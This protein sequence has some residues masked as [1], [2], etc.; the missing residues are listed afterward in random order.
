MVLRALCILLLT[1]SF[2]AVAQ[3]QLLNGGFEIPDPNRATQWFTPP[4]HWDSFNFAGIRSEYIPEPEYGQVVT[5]TIPAPYEGHSFLLLSTGDVEGPGSDPLTV[6]SSLEQAITVCPGNVLYGSYF[7]GTCDYRPYNDTG[8]IKLIPVDPNDG[9][10]P[11]LLVS[12]SV[13]DLGNFQSTDGWQHFSYMFSDANCGQYYIYCE[14][15]DI[16]DSRYQ[17][18]LAL[19][20][21]RICQGAPAYGDLNSDCDVDYDDLAILGRSWLADC[22]DPNVIADPNIPCQLLIPDPNT[23][24][25]IIEIEHLM[26]LSENWLEQLSN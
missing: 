24:G 2:C 5:W 8:L 13:D 18:Y 6:F 26:L 19:D 20:N 12:I 1:C 16:L 17:S 25:N 7:F 22:N 4:L 23:L 10:R 15:R 14:V 11:I 3:G 21:F 9:L